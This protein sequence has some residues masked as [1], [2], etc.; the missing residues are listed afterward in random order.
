MAGGSILTSA[1]G[2]AWGAQG[3]NNETNSPNV[4]P[5]LD[6]G[7]YAYELWLGQEARKRSGKQFADKLDEQ[8]REFNAQSALFNKEA[9]ATQGMNALQYLASQ[10][11]NAETLGRNRSVRD[12]ILFS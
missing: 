9:G 7:R 11:M 3:S 4:S 6:P 8:K 5:G 2:S 12:S 1:L 10:R